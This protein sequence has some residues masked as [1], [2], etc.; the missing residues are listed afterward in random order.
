[1][2]GTEKKVVTA[3]GRDAERPTSPKEVAELRARLLSAEQMVDPLVNVLCA[4]VRRSGGKAV[5]TAQELKDL[6]A[7]LEIRSTQ[8]KVTKDVTLVVV[9]KLPDADAVRESGL[10]LPIGLG[11]L[12]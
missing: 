8:D 1:M 7:G 12:Q 4:L 9:R 3:D 5:V 6:E 10:T 11:K 2:D